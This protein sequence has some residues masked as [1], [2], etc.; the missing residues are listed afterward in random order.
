MNIKKD[1]VLR[2]VFLYIGVLIGAFLIVGRIVFLQFVEGDKWR[3]R[4]RGVSQTNVSIEANRGD[5]LAADG[6][7]LASSIPS[8]GVYMDFKADG[9]KS[10]VFYS[11][12]D[13]LSMTL[14]HFFRDKSTSQYR[15]F[16]LKGW[17]K[18]SRYY[19][20]T[21]RQISYTELQIIKKFPLF[22]LG[23]N[24]G[25]FILKQY[26]QR[27]KPFGVLASRTIGKLY[28]DKAKG[29]MVGLEEAYDDY[30][31]GEDGVG[32]KRKMSGRWVT[33]EVVEPRDGN[34]IMT[35]IDVNFQDVAEFALL[36][37]LKKHNA[38]HGTVIL[39]EVESGDVKAIVNLHQTPSGNFNEDYFNYAIGEATEP[40]STFKL[41]SM[42]VALEDGVVDL[43]DTIDTGNGI[44]YYHNVKM[45]DSHEGGFGKLS[46][47]EVFAHSS[48]VGVSKIIQDNYGKDPKR[49]TERLYAMGLNKPLGLTIKGE[50]NP[51]IKY[52]GRIGE[53]SGIT[54]PWMSIGYEVAMTPLQILTFY[55]GIANDGAVVKPRFVKSI[56]YHGTRV[57]TVDTEI[58]NP[59][60]CSRQTLKKAKLM[61][62]A[63]VE[64]GTATNLKNDNYKIAGKTGTAQVAQGTSGYRNKGRVQHQA[65]FCGYFPADNPKYSCIVVI[66]GPSRNVIYG[67]VVAGTV[68]KEISDK[69][70]AQQIEMQRETDRSMDEVPYKVPVTKDGYRE[71][72]VTVFNELN[73]PASGLAGESDW[74]RTYNKG[75]YIELKDQTVR[76]RFVPNVSGMGA[77]DALFLLENAGLKVVL[78][79]RGRVKKQSLFPGSVINKGST[80]YITLG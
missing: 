27:K 60:I 64:I 17:K 45:E 46:V 2:M 40:G 69:V 31:S 24:K 55:N 77:R 3:D 19:R 78:T 39:M 20:I 67:N 57:Q 65:S 73:V 13:S 66:N 56:Y 14:S 7:L 16:L 50:G 18:G 37:Q 42:L 38:E 52:P 48:N 70:Y 58:L 9:L 74:V 75:D 36:E 25:G 35:T 28:G 43:N 5:I 71:D 32:V 22:R 10:A 1:I 51:I 79:G 80:I 44:T 15:R 54:L 61:L 63:V 23:S 11:K 34:D 29:G 68:F 8:Y 12:L 33:V 49:F 21:G 59:S 47:K 62:E 76:S 53:W 72:L 26:D 6:R 4:Q 30:L 41:A